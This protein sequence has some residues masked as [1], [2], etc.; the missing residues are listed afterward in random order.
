MKSRIIRSGPP[1]ERGQSA[2]CGNQDPEIR[3]SSGERS[4]E[5][6]AE[7]R[8]FLCGKSVVWAN[9]ENPQLL[10]PLQESTLG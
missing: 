6:D 1:W 8:A 10:F 3:A 4:D 7:A 5:K 9:L 2:R